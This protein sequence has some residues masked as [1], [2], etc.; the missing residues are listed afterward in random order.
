LPPAQRQ[1]LRWINGNRGP[2]RKHAFWRHLIA[3]PQWKEPILL[4]PARRFTLVFRLLMAWTFIYAASHQI[5]NPSFSVATF[6]GHTKTFH[7]VYALFATPALDPFLTLLV[8]YGHLLIGLSLLVGLMVRV[9]AAFAI[10]LLLMYWTAHMEWPFIENQNNF[11]VDYH[12][13][14]AVVCGYLI[15]MRAG[16]VWGLDAW[17]RTLP[18]V[19]RHPAL[20]LLFA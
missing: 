9:S 12:I 6:L 11:I 18:P 1:E 5:F 14:Y 3:K 17:A 13:V 8:G 19:A 7:D 15:A 2:A 10:A 20:G 16:Q 4:D